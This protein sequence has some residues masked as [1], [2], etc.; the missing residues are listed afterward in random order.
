MSGAFKDYLHWFI[1]LKSQHFFSSIDNF[2][3]Y[4]L[5]LNFIHIK[6]SNL[7]ARHVLIS[8][9]H[10]QIFLTSMWVQGKKHMQALLHRNVWSARRGHWEYTWNKSIIYKCCRIFFDKLIYISPSPPSPIYSFL[11]PQFQQRVGSI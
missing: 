7:K 10:S 11:F 1:L 6:S 4:S 8:R 9:N 2:S 3:V 5:H